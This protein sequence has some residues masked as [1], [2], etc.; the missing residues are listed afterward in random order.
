MIHTNILKYNRELCDSI[1]SRYIFISVYLIIIPFTMYLIFFS[2]AGY[3]K[4]S[5]LDYS[6]ADAFIRLTVYDYIMPCIILYLIVFFN[7]YLFDKINNVSIIRHDSRGVIWTKQIYKICIS[8]LYISLYVVISL[9]IVSLL[10][11]DSI[12]NFHLKNSLFYASTYQ[13]NY[14]ITIFQ[15]V[16]TSFISLYIAGFIITMLIFLVQWATDK[17]VFGWVIIISFTVIDVILKFPFF[18]RVM[19]NNYVYLTDVNHLVL[20]MA[21]PLI[22]FLAISITGFII[23][24]K[25][26]FLNV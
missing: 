3:A 13:L 5:D 14:S 16:I 21:N 2:G 9:V 24:R 1:K 17:A 26:D 20:R 12:I 8:N 11:T 15:V 6:M 4:F 18:I 10:K 22:W 7:F 25:K 23:S 19:S